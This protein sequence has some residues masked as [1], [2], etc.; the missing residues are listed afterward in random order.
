VQVKV[1]KVVGALG[2]VATGVFDGLAVVKDCFSGSTGNCGRA[3]ARVG[4][5]TLG[6]IAGGACEFFT[7]GIATPICFGIVAGASTLGDY[8]LRDRPYGS[9]VK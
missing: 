3:W 9:R 4:V 6:A 1:A 5:D 7:A 2:T 8:L